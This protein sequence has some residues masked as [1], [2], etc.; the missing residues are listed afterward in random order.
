MNFIAVPPSLHPYSNKLTVKYC[1]VPKSHANINVFHLLQDLEIFEN[2]KH[3]R[4]FPA[5]VL[6]VW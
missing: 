6:L 3:D 1:I 4:E 5:A 2:I